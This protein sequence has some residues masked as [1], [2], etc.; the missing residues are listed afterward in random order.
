MNAG[1]RCSPRSRRNRDQETIQ[2]P[3]AK[4]KRRE[5]GRGR[6]GFPRQPFRKIG[7]GTGDFVCKIFAERVNDDV[8]HGW[9]EFVGRPKAMK[10]GEEMERVL[11]IRQ[12]L[13]FFVLLGIAQAG[14]T[15]RRYSVEEE[16]ENDVFV[17]NLLKDLGLEVEELAARGPQ[18][19]SKGKKL[20]LELNRQTGDLLLRERLD[21][22]ELC[23]P[24][25]SCVVPFQVLLGNPLQIFQAELQIR[26]INDH[27]P[28][29]LDKEII[30]KI[31]EMTS[32]G[33]TFLIE[34]AQDLDVGINSLQTYTISP[35]FYFYLKLQDS[36]DGTVLPQL[37]LDK[38]LDREEQSEI[39]LILTAID[40]G[41]PPR[42]G[43]ALIIIE[44]LDINDNAPTFSKFRYEVQV[45]ENSPVGFQ[46]A[47]VSA[48]DLDIGDY[49]QIAYGF[50]Q[51]SED[52]RKTFRMNASSGEILLAKTLDFESTQTYTIYIQA[53]DGG[54]LS[55]SSVV[56]VQVMDL[57]DNPPEL[58]MSTLTKHIPENSP[59][60]VIAVFSVADP[61][62]GDNG[63]TVCYIPE[64]LP[65]I[66]KPSVEN[67]YTLMTNTA[68][69][70]ETRSQYN[71]TITI[72]DL[73]TPRL[74]TQHTITVQVSDINDNAP[75]FTQT[76]Y[77]LF[78][79]EN[80]SP[81]LHIGSIRAA[82]SDS[83]SNAHIT[84]S[85]L[86]IQNLQLD[87]ASLI[88][89]NADNG[90][91]FALRAL[92]YESLQTFQFHVG[93]TD[94]GSPALTSQVLVRV[95][96]LDANDNAP[97][98]LYPLQ[99]ASA[100][101]TELLPRA[102][103]PGY[104]VTKVV[105]VD[106]DSGQNAWLSF[107]LLKAT[108]PGLFNVWAHNGEVRTSRLLS[109][110]DVPKHRLVLLVKD[111]GNPQRSTS[112]TL[113]VLLVDGFS[114]PYLPLPEVARDPV[115][116][117]DMLTLY[118]VIA[119]ASV[120]SLFLLSVLLFV[121]VRLCRRARAASLSGL[122]VP[123]GHFPGHLVDVSGTGTL[124]QSYQYEVCLT[125]DSGTTDFKFLKPAI[126]GFLF[127][128]SERETMA[129]RHCI[130]IKRKHN[131]LFDIGQIGG[132]L[133]GSGSRRY[134]VAEE[135]EK[136]F[137]IANLG[138]DMGLTVEELAD[139]RAQAI[140]KGNIQYF[141][142]SHQTGDLLLVEKLD[143]EE[144]CGSTEPCVLHFQILLHNPLQF[145]T[146]ELEVIDINDNAPEFFENAMQLKVPESSPP[147]TVIPLVNAVDLD[148]G[149]NGLQNYT[150]S[151]MSHFHVRTRHR[152]DGRK[153]PELVLDR[154]LDREEQ[155]ELSLTLTALDGG[156][157]PRSG[158]AQVHIL[159]LDINDN[160]PDF[161]QSLYEVQIL[162]NSPVGSVIITVSAS[163]LDTGNFGAISYAFFHASEDI[164]K[165]FQINSITGDIQLVKGLD[166]EAINTY[167]VDIEAKDGGGLSGKCTVIVQVVDV[168]D[169]PPEMTL[170]SVNSPIPENSAETV[171]AV[172]SVADLDSGD[173]GKVT[174][175]I[176]NDL[177][178]ILKLSVEN[179][180]TIVS[181]GALDRESR[182]EYSITI[183]VTDMGTPRLTT[184]HTITVQVSDINDNA[185]AFTQTSYTLFVQENNS[186]ALHIGT[187]SATDSDSGSNAHITYS[188]LPIQDPQLFLSSLISINADNGQ[189]FV[190]R[191]LD[192]ESLQTFEFGVV[193]T[194]QGSPVLSTQALVRVHVLD[195]ND[196]EPFV[197]Y[198]LQNASA[199][200]TELL[201]RAAEPGY[202]V[203]KVVAVDRDSGQNAWLSFQLL[204]ATEP[205][206]FSVWA[207]NGEV[208]TSRLL[209]ERDAPKHRLVLLVKDNG[210]PPCSASVTLHVLLV[211]GF[212]Q[213]YLPLPEVARDPVQDEDM[214][215]LYLVIALAS[216]S[217][218]FLLSVLLFV[219]M[220][221]CRKA[222]AASLGVCS[223]PE[224][225]FPGHLVD[226]S[227]T[228]TLS[229]SYRYEVCLKGDSGTG[230]FKFLN[231]V[232]RSTWN[233]LNILKGE[234]DKM[235][236]KR[237]SA[238]KHGHKQ[239]QVVF[240]T[241]LLL[242]CESGTEAIK[243]FML[244]EMESGYLVAT[245]EKD[246]G[247]RVG[248]LAT[249]G[250]RIHH[251][252]NKELL[253]LDAETGNL[254]LKEKLDREELC[255]VTEPCVLH[256][257]LILKTPVQFFQ[258]DLQLTDI[259]DHFP[260][261]PHREMLLK[262]PENVQPGTVFSLKAAQDSDIGSNAV[263]NY[264]VSPNLHFHVLTQSRADG[265]KYPELVLDR[266]LDREE[267]PELS[268]T[269]TALDGGS[270]PR[271]GTMTVRIEVMDINDNAPQFVQSLYEVQVP[272]NSPLDT[273]V[274]KVFARDLDA[275][276]HGNVAYSLF[277]GDGASQTFV[278][279]EVT[280]EIR[281]N[282]ELD[283]E[284]TNH[285][286]IEI[287]ATDG[288]GFSSKCMMSVQ[289]LDVN[290]NAPELTISTLTS[291]IPENSQETAVAVFSVFDL[292]SG[293][294][295]RMACSIKNDIPF[296]L[297]PTIENYYTVVTEG[298][299]DRESRA[300][301]NIT[302]TVTDLGTPRLTT[303][304]TITVQVSDVNDNAPAFK[305]TSYTLFVQENNSPALHIGTISATD[306]DSGS[307]AHITY[308]LLPTDDP[309]LV[310]SSLISINADNGQLFA[311]RAL[312]YEILKTFEF[313][314]VAT[315][316]GSPVLSSQVLVRVHVLDVNDNEPFVLYPLQNSSAP[317]TELLPRAAEPGYLVTKV[318]AVDRD[319]GQNAWLS[320]Q[321]LKATEP[322]LFSVWAHN[323]EVRTSRL[324]SER[325][326]AKHRLVLL[327]KDNGDPPYSASVTLHV[328]LVDG[329]S[330]PYLPL[331]EVARDP[332]Q[333][334]DMLTLYLVIALASVSSL[335]LLSVLLFVGVRL[336]RRARAASLG[337]CSVPEGHFP[338]HLVDV[339]GTGTLSQSYQ[340]E[341]CLT[342]DSGTTDFKFL[343]P[344]IPNKEMNLIIF[345]GHSRDQCLRWEMT[346]MCLYECRM[347]WQVLMVPTRYSILEET[348][349]GSFVAHLAKD[350]GLSSGDLSVRS[351][352]V[353]SDY[354]K[355]QLILDPE[356]GDLLLREKLDREELCASVDPCV[357][358]F[359]V[360]LEKPVQFLEGELLIQDVND[361]SPEFPDRE[362]LLKILENSQPGTRFSLKSAQD[363]D[364]GSNGLQQYTVSPTSH[365]HV[366]TRNHS[367]GKKYPELVQDRALD[368]EEQAELSLTLTALDGG[369]PPRSGTAV[370]RILILDINDNAPKFVNT[371][372]EVQVLESS[373]QDTPVLTV[374]AQDADACNF[375]R[376]SYGLFQASDEIQQTF[377][378]NEVTGEIR[379]KKG[380]DF[381]KIKSYHLEIEATDGGGLSGKGSVMIE[382]MDVNDNAPELTM[383]SL[384][385]S[386]PENVPETVVAIFRIRDRDSGENGKIICSIPDTLP[387]ILKPSHKNFYTLV[388]ESPLDRENRAE[389]N[390]TIMVTD[391][392]TP[393]LTTQH[394]ITV[395]VSDINDNAPAF[396]QT[397]YTLFVQENN[398]PALH[399]G[400]ISATDSDSGSN[401]HITYS[402]LPTDD[403]Q[404]VL[405]SLISIN[406][407]NGQLFVLRALDY[408]AL[409][410][411]EFG[412]VAT[413]QGSPALSSQALV[414]V[415]VLDA[416]DNEPFVLYPLQ[417]ASA[418]CTELL[419]RAAEPGYLVT[420]VVA[421]DRD[422]GQNAWLSFQLLKATEPGLFSVWAHNGE[423]RT[424]RLLSERDVAKHRL[425]LLVKDN[426]D[427]PC[428]ASVTLHVLLVD[429]F[430]QPYLP[431]P[432]VA[433]DPV[434]DED[435]LTLYLVIALASVS[436]FFLLSVLLF[437]G[438]RLCRRARAASLGGFSVPEGHFPGH[439]VDVSGTGTLSQSYQYEVCLTQDS[440]T[441]CLAL[442][443]SSMMQSEINNLENHTQEA[444]A[445]AE[446]IKELLNIYFIF[447]SLEAN[448]V[449][450]QRQVVFLAI[451]LLLWE[452]GTKGMRYSMPEETESGYL[453]ANLE[454]DL[455]LRV[456]E[457][458]TRGARI[459]HRGN[460]ELLHL[461][462]E[463][464][465][466]LL[467]VK[468]DREVL[469]GVTE[470]CVLH[471][472]LILENPVQFFQIDLQL[473]DI[474]DHSPEF[475]HREML[476]NIQESAQPGTVFPLKA[477][478]D[479]DIGS[480]AVQNYTVSPNLHFHVFT[481]S[482]ADGSKYPELVLDRA[483]DREEQPELSL[484]LTA[485]DGG[486]P[487]R[488]GTMTVRIEVLDIN[489]NA[490]QFVQSL[491][492]VQVP[493]NSP[494]NTLVVAVSARD[495]DAGIHGNVVYS[496]FQGNEVSQPFVI[497]KVTGEIRLKRVLDFEETPYYNMEIVA[498]DSGGLSGKCGVAI[499]VV[500]VN[501][502]A[503]K[504]TISSLTSSIPENAP[505]IVVTVFSVSDP[506]SGD[507][508]KMVCSIQNNLPFLLKPTFENYYTVVTEGPLDRESRAEY[509]ITITVTDLGTPRLTTQHT[510]T[511]QVS[512]INDN[513]PAFTQTSYTLFVQENNSPALH[514]GTISATDSDSGSNAHITYSLLP[515]DDPQLALSSLIS[516]NA[517]N[518]Q[519]F[520]LRALDYESLQT[521]EF[522]VGATDQGSPAL[523]SQALVR[524][525]VL[526]ANDNVPFV[527]YPLQNAS[528]PCTELLPRAAEPGYLVTKVVAV[529]Q[530]S[531]QN[532]WLSFQLLKA[533]E[534]GLFSVW[535][536]NGEV[537]T[538][539]LLSDRDAPKHRLVLLVK[540]NGDPPCSASVSLHVLLVDGFSQPYLPLPE[541]ARDSVYKCSQSEPTTPY[542]ILEE[543]ESGSFVAHL[544][545]DLGLSSG[546]LSA[547]SAR[548]VSD[549][550][551]QRL[552]LDPET[553]DLLLREKLDREELCA[554]V[555][556]CV[557]H[558]QVSLEKPVQY[559]QGELLIQDVN[560]HS[561]E[562][563]D[564]EMLLK[565]PENSQPGTRFSLKLAQ[566]L[567]VG[568]S[569]L[570]QYTVSP[571]S[572]F[573]VLTRNHSEGKKYPELVQDRALDREEQA[574]LSLTLTALDGGSPP[575]S[576]TA[577]IRILI[578]DI[579]DNVP[580]FV[581]TPYE[582]QVL[583]SS[584]PDTPV[585]TVQ[586]QDADAGNFGRVSYGLF[587]ASDE[588]QQTFSINEVTGEIRLKKGLDFEK[589]KS[590]HL[591]IEATDGGGLSGKGSVMIEVMD[592]NDNAPELTISSLTSSV[593]ENAPEVIISIFRVGDR[594]SGE[595]GKVVCSIAENLPFILK[596]TYKNF[597]TL[598][599]ETPLDRESRA[600]YNITIT[601]TDL[602][603]PRLTTQHTIKVLVSD[604]ND[605]A[606]TFTQTSYTLFI[607]ENNS[608]ALH[609]GTISATDSDSGSNAH[610]TYSLLPIDGPQLVLSSLISINADNGQLFALRALDYE[611]L[612]TFEFGVVATDQGSPALSSQVLVRVLVLDANDNEPFVLY[613]LQN[614]SAPC[615]E[616]LPRAAEP[617]Y[618]VTKVV[619]VDQD[620][621][622]N[623][624]LS[625]QL[626][627]ATEPGLFSVWAH[628]G[629]VRT[630]RLLSER[631]APKH[632]LV[633]LVKDNGDPPCSASVSL[634]VLLVDG[635][636]QPYLPLPE[637]TRDSVQD[638]DML[639]LYLV[640]ALASVSSLFLL[641]VLL[642]VGVR[643]CRRARAASLDGCSVP[644]GR[645][646]GHLVDV[647]GAGTLTQSYQYEVCLTGDSG[648]GEFKFLKPMFPNLLLQDPEREIKESP[649]CRDSFVF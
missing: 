526:D 10:A 527:L 239:R 436:S 143:R 6:R 133:A 548:V 427:P 260:V 558:F 30:L 142:L 81:A 570:Q 262:I 549:D 592:V 487:P 563:P 29:F 40:G 21:Q 337:G 642:F 606:P 355:Q 404:L 226:V 126:P 44:V 49:G 635:F 524:I 604:V 313:H 194:D 557:L 248:E 349:S 152:R 422:S 413:D 294:S 388:T 319:S 538:S 308:S 623:A 258:I 525:I 202:L 162:E 572:H 56:F 206:L 338:G 464:G 417:N 137:L 492:E 594:D 574:E 363:L 610:I 509:N 250:A 195:A 69:D 371:P 259:N 344:I 365:F 253:Q 504:L 510:V 316:Q 336:C 216:V 637:V 167:E 414:R 580:Q 158:T 302:I 290:D 381:E 447:C 201:P 569:G 203:T 264:T 470:P 305:Q 318:V 112:V 511:V 17:A 531:G 478:Q 293:D 359:Q 498:T 180:Y 412:V 586:A 577:M 15:L 484:I 618:L 43:T 85:L 268:L 442:V 196:N 66:L 91:L 598:V 72:T 534:P 131:Y 34:R 497:D 111:N 311:L 210:D 438:V 333:D 159:V 477:A 403:P 482:R 52:I 437:I 411:F 362:M 409:K 453:V 602:G 89:I 13:L 303:Q 421:V 503:P 5:E 3:H 434:Q 266:A 90:Q 68:L 25:E 193:A 537:R 370:I 2:W 75:A 183:T 476:L 82:D 54:G 312:D 528:A 423:V 611:S 175:S 591:E 129:T 385:S 173:N 402:L 374:L 379:L 483:L 419:P 86:P 33:T 160:A 24:A 245:L 61:D 589:T 289:V 115:Q 463:T 418:S 122:S 345:R 473:T 649:H 620:S 449:C 51:A 481:Q 541:V 426:G 536:H 535:A 420:K 431:L 609:I 556:P 450:R 96:V 265:S 397:S 100:P 372:Y 12:V 331:P 380:L 616:L 401:A 273:I 177:P 102:A 208:R 47:T 430:S 489:D 65:F 636:S 280:G 593:P 554:S 639:T 432:E 348:E 301:Y 214:L 263:Q 341:V 495:L 626:L 530:D 213:P 14:S 88:S 76:S 249:R 393:R 406:T 629:E 45:P 429:G 267:Q 28:V 32:S 35:N 64:D 588:I 230:E 343:K 479:S 304:H 225:H 255:G 448:L 565:I 310:L 119:L 149:R 425:V 523:S 584:L 238:L 622:Q 185:P 596:S 354:D 581:N 582:V 326:V 278:I 415:H 573:H 634:H 116:D 500:D 461:D 242:L 480:N 583:E 516:I 587:Q 73:G 544:A 60:T 110:R 200:C 39:R 377:S 368:R 241:I 567:D 113:H 439:L 562:F 67:F 295:G 545:K 93:A 83:G 7:L 234:E 440:G 571:T 190:L 332:V 428:S 19:I 350:L 539:R 632:R 284:V 322:G 387:F 125:G 444:E 181:E 533:T 209:S 104:L 529:D 130:L 271:S 321:L 540:D 150:V 166:Y 269:L 63:K 261:F 80:N 469:C 229:Q 512:D 155:S 628:N 71:I 405:S 395:Q 144:L 8:N 507:N 232:F 227:G 297:K 37:V 329:F 247:L 138:K 101:C 281:L 619:A 109:E 164:L 171:V 391:L 644:E 70:R 546:E 605:N 128:S 315:D 36:P 518:G 633:L 564:R 458:V 466:L 347:I 148:V 457:L 105:A 407:D 41:S 486:S 298:P 501:D 237:N 252:G 617:G 55:G 174:C 499:Q 18:I 522:H 59:E 585:L 579:N 550:Y 192:Y 223:V 460:K 211:E 257:Q 151:P 48:R 599:T 520:A 288:G 58:T 398:S 236:R 340:Y 219:G 140:S 356:T 435:M 648:T 612:Q 187:I 468:P 603:T 384:T 352:R 197:L 456:G 614:A 212:S 296:L 552:L 274:V 390:I 551:K 9:S 205:G 382:V 169:N 84:Y 376:V 543:T 627:K 114:Q 327:V 46:V 608:P 165:K 300:E 38:V 646:P 22:E 218:L 560:D 147:G 459:H 23:G 141:Q 215:T 123:E 191:A 145:I 98:V 307:N 16:K 514:I 383:S 630:S 578:L 433:S 277:Q 451:M 127:Q 330:Q 590:Y 367:E 475:P 389:Y 87:L 474:N 283:F 186:P 163:D 364:V 643:L 324:L 136:G 134:S 244:E 20:N 465:N 189:L 146:N 342:G 95:L 276:V 108:E 471:F 107:Q 27:S 467:R 121:G 62:S 139:R 153:Y 157:P 124:S 156:S 555:D 615:T 243:Y 568:S 99:N 396:T 400:T 50:S 513:A 366:L 601:V 360:F 172:F 286:N 154:A 42:S 517:D 386:I 641:S 182:A 375:G 179:F 221:L 521:F 638:E 328:L 224:G 117:E 559:F 287:A 575:R 26:D 254:L 176:Q 246:L 94:Q 292:D 323:G 542:S 357:L 561:P 597:Y 346:H 235:S 31:S 118:L 217:S 455:G 576:G 4:G 452:S 515:T 325:D 1:W 275:G 441:G 306:S 424:S 445:E 170:S 358:H 317:C 392:G 408:E 353:V 240:L 625:F 74:T 231:P 256:F 251:R 645:F 566:D 532:A 494:L 613:P 394:T 443:Y 309:Q 320:F 188:L 416:N 207:H 496:L 547:R 120:S 373:L 600:E 472:Q 446:V 595:N 334:E 132:C 410:A 282:K 378:I 314:V 505:E 291:P 220:R 135:K 502:N 493:E 11:K 53:T 488:S 454:R 351:A 222:R 519:L 233:E 624:W 279:D 97:F 485:L 607:Q 631:D 506:D 77:T 553:G 178:F 106:Q 270:P 647:S 228:G 508:G 168:N 335:F 462:A 339:S 640:I 161:T 57:N 399:I 199:P 184:Q 491:Y 299:L 79:Q 361:H 198:P 369:A 103:E 78:V 621:G 204:K 272:E 285:Y 490:P 92:D